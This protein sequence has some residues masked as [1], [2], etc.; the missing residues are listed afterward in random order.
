MRSKDKTQCLRL[1]VLAAFLVLVTAVAVL[2][3]VKG[4]GPQGIPS[5]HTICPFGGLETVYRVVAGGEFLKR[6]NTAN[7]IILAGTI[8]LALLFGRYFCGWI[9]ALGFL[10]ELPVRLGGRLLKK[11]PVLP[12]SLDRPLRYLKYLALAAILF[13][14]WKL[15]D[16][17]VSPYDPFAAYAH[18]P[19]GLAELLDEFLIG[20]GVLVAS[21]VLSFF[22]HRAFC[23]YLCPMGAFLALVDRIGLFRISRDKETCI[24]CGRCSAACPANIPVAKLDRVKDPECLACLEC[25]SACPTG[26]QTLKPRTAGH[27]WHPAV[28]GVLGLALYLG[29]IGASMLVGLWKTTEPT[30][31]AV[32]TKGGQLDPYSIRGFMTVEEVAATFGLEPGDIWRQLGVDPAAAPAGVRVKELRNHFPELDE[33]AVREAV[34]RILEEKKE[35]RP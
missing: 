15:G 13:F 19:A 29:L 28:M 22:Y 8:L 31:E 16:L 20:L 30:L 17:V 4:G 3:Q 2:H 25:V 9:C 24:D 11:R 33:D 27:P 18:I 32:V 35:G 12:K 21:L 5:I 10:Q 14:T 34:A 23:K 7:F 26:K 1:A 6:T